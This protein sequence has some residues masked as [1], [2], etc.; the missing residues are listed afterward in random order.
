[1]NLLTAFAEAAGRGSAHGLHVLNGDREA[2]HAGYDELY[3]DAGHLACGLLT[4][5]V[6]AGE[7]V[8]IAL[9]TSLNFARAFFG[10]LAAGA[11]PVPVP[12]PVRYAPAHVRTRRISLILRQSN[13]RFILS[14]STLG[15]LLKA[16]LGGADGEFTIMDV[17]TV[18]EPSTVYADVTAEDVALVQ[19]TSGTIGDPR[20]VLLSHGNLLANVAAITRGLGLTDSDVCCSWLPMFHDMGLIGT[21]LCSMLSDVETY[22]LPPEHFLRDPGRWLRM[23]D[24]YRGTVAAAPSSGYLHTLRKVPAPEVGRFDLSSWRLALNGAENVDTHVMR[25]FAEHFA[26]AGFRYAAFLP[27]YGLAEATLAVAFPPV[28]REPKTAWVRRD[29]LSERA[30]AFSPAGAERARELASVGAAVAGVQIR[31]MGDEQIPLDAEDRVGE[32]QVRG[33]SVMRGYEGHEEAT[34]QTIRDDGWVATGDLGFWHHDELHIAGR[35]KEMIIV[36][37]E[38]YYASDI[39]SI[40]GQVPG[41]APGGA[42]AVSVSTAGGEAL[43]LFIETSANGDATRTDLADRARC[44]VSS[45]LGIS[46]K[47]IILVPRGYLP[48]T[49]SGKLQ[50]HHA[51]GDDLVEEVLAAGSRRTGAA[52]AGSGNGEVPSSV[53]LPPLTSPLQLQS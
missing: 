13:V 7:R 21:L 34:R 40:A 10:V 47:E 19:Y 52:P 22:L 46:P 43:V 17:G 33:T 15:E 30:V 42:L 45:T 44:A 11:V 20:G 39:E 4:R 51:R 53:R 36:G 37:G 24:R 1:M 5:G 26:P 38:N 29:L 48:R 49:S 3:A 12:P 9:P 2:E 14:A 41:V 50:R 8:A 16:E 25:R 18:P 28:G 31:L 23:I 27:V 35:K 6:T 32:I